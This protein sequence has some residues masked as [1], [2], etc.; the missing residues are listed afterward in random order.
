[1]SLDEFIA[2]YNGKQVEYHSYNPNAKFQCVDLVNQYIVE[3]LHLEPLIGTNAKDFPEKINKDHFEWIPNTPDG[4]PQEGDIPIWNGRVGGGAGHIAIALKGSTINTLK[5]FDQNWSKPLYCTLESHTYTNVRGWLRP[6][7]TDIIDEMPT[8]LKDLLKEQL[9]LNVESSEGDVRARVG[10]IVDKERNYDD[11]QK[12]ITGLEKE[13]SQYA[14]QAAGLEEELRLSNK[15]RE[16]LE[17]EIDLLKKDLTNKDKDI[18]DLEERIAT[19]EKSI[20]PSTKVI[21]DK[22]VWERL[23]KKRVLDRATDTELVKEF[24]TRQYNKIKGVF[25]K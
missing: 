6:K 15:T 23:Q 9:K 2:K 13:V 7:K 4:K 16:R 12:R 25:F 19:L 1:M 11:L 5:S 14:S 20:D 8:W 24:F 18:S 17:T 3:V 10:Q 22:D 21:V